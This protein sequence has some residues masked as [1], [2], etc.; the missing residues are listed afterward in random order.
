[1]QLFK[2]LKVQLCQLGIIS[3]EPNR[4]SRYIAV[5]IRCSLFIVYISKPILVAWYL[6]FESKTFREHLKC[7]SALLFVSLVL[8]WY[9]ALVFQSEKYR[10]LLDELD[11]II[12]KSKS[13]DRN[14][15][16]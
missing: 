15:T 3:I 6:I 14:S 11:L 5:V 1:M 13:I 16:I 4:K 8:T 12:E 10:K 2:E 9:S 7:I